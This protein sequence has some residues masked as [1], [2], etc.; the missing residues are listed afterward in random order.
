ML[1][2]WKPYFSENDHEQLLSFIDKVIIGEPL[3]RKFLIIL[4]R[5]EST[6]KLRSDILNLIP[7]NRLIPERLRCLKHEDCDKKL[8]YFTKISTGTVANIKSIAER[9]QIASFAK[10]NMSILLKYHHK[11]PDNPVN[12]PAKCNVILE[13]DSFEKLD[14]SLLRRAVIVTMIR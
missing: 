12:K 2:E 3:K 11:D 10:C 1:E 14:G 5:K 13:V 8:L 4:G 9:E 6:E 7:E